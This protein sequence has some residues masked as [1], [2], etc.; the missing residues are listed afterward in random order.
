MIDLYNEVVSA[1]MEV[2]EKQ[3]RQIRRIISESNLEDGFADLDELIS[4]TQKHRDADKF[5]NE[6]GHFFWLRAHSS[7]VRYAA[8]YKISEMIRQIVSANGED[9][10]GDPYP[11]LRDEQ[12][13]NVFIEA[14]RILSLD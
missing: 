11:A 5:I 12:P 14:K 6:L 7:A 13:S 4:Q 9:H 3:E 10:W 8:I 2:R 1:E